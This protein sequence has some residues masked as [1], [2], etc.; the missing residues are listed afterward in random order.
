MERKSKMWTLLTLIIISVPVIEA[1]CKAGMTG[2]SCDKYDLAYQKRAYQKES[3][4][5]LSAGRAVDGDITKCT[6]APKVVDQPSWTVDLGRDMAVEGLI[7]YADDN[8][9]AQLRTFT[10]EIRKEGATAWQMCNHFNQSMPVRLETTCRTGAVNGQYVKVTALHQAFKLELC[11]VSVYGYCLGGSYGNYCQKTCGNCLAGETCSTNTGECPSGCE[12]G[13]HENTCDKRCDDGKWGRG[14]T[15]TCG[16]CA[17]AAP[18]S[19]FTGVCPNAGLCEP[20]YVTGNCSLTCPDGTTGVGCQPCGHCE[21]GAACNHT[22][23]TCYTGCETG[24]IYH[25]QDRTCTTVCPDGAWGKA[26]SDTCENECGKCHV[27]GQVVAGTCNSSTGLCSD[28]CAS[29]YQQTENCKVECPYFK[30]G[31]NCNKDC[32]KCG[33]GEGENR[34]LVP[35]NN[36]DGTCGVGCIYGWSGIFCD[37]ECDPGLYGIDCT[38]TCG[39]CRS[40]QCDIIDGV[41]PDFEC[42]DGYN[43]SDTTCKTECRPGFYGYRCANR[44]PSNCAEDCKVETVSGNTMC[45]TVCGPKDGSCTCKDGYQGPRCEEERIVEVYKPYYGNIIGGVIGGVIALGLIIAFVVWVVWRYRKDKSIHIKALASSIRQSFR[46]MSQR[47]GDGIRRSIQ[48]LSRRGRRQNDEKKLGTDIDPPAKTNG[49]KGH[50]NTARMY[51]CVKIHSNTLHEDNFPNLYLRLQEATAD[52][53]TLLHDAFMSFQAQRPKAHKEQ[54]GSAGHTN[55]AYYNAASSED[56]QIHLNG[57]GTAIPSFLPLGSNLS[58]FLLINE[59]VVSDVLWNHLQQRQIELIISLGKESTYSW[60]PGERLNIGPDVV[61]VIDMQLHPCHRETKLTVQRRGGQGRRAVRHLELYFWSADEL[62]PNVSTLLMFMETFQALHRAQRER[63]IIVNFLS[64]SEQAVFFTLA[65]SC[66]EILAESQRIDV[67]RTVA[68][69]GKATDKAVRTFE[70]FK[71]LHDVVFDYIAQKDNKSYKSPPSQQY[72]S[73]ALHA[74][75]PKISLDRSPEAQAPRSDAHARDRN[76]KQPGANLN[77]NQR[78]TEPSLSPNQYQQPRARAGSN[79]RQL[80]DNKAGQRRGPN[81]QRSGMTSQQSDQAQVHQRRTSPAQGQQPTS[82]Q[83]RL[84]APSDPRSPGVYSDERP[85]APSDPRSRDAYQNPKLRAP[86]EPRSPAG[87]SDQKPR[88]LTDPRSTGQQPRPPQTVDGEFSFRPINSEVKSQDQPPL[89]NSVADKYPAPK[90]QQKRLSPSN[91]QHHLSNGTQNNR[92]PVS[93]QGYQ[94]PEGRKHFPGGQQQQRSRD[95]SP[96]R[97][98]DQPHQ[99]PPVTQ[100]NSRSRGASPGRPLDQ[101]NQHQPYSQHN[102]RSRGASP[103]RTLDQP[104]QQPPVTQQNSRSRGASP[105]RTLD[106]GHREQAHSRGL[107]PGGRSPNEHQ[108]RSRAYSEHPQTNEQ[109]HE[110]RSR[111]PSSSTVV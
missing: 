45:T 103:G 21:G 9:T 15:K 85:R 43:T 20:G 109:D 40:G 68:I 105:G 33:A 89:Y 52:G 82:Q 101:P 23:G 80:Y 10:I 66:L 58:G 78:Q 56:V 92:S 93:P 50:H 46:R 18:C 88:A 71:F 59:P 54:N 108:Q 87:S 22:D 28:G 44:C 34:T 19:V 75:T 100:H 83:Q 41:C 17:D 73:V 47:G 6:V 106:P 5:T 79:E 84:R 1:Q 31:M 49:V 39:N 8:T 81:E 30:Y 72:H 11:E 55:T 14:C 94:D 107:S 64:M 97:T 53:R 37:K 77:Q 62:Y 12:A 51:E 48:R 29:G 102:S 26:S 91:Q 3:W 63:S 90:N 111:F 104:H 57:E 99:Q 24:Y 98:L 27:P 110:Q 7:I 96:G 67:L 42:A 61:E 76:F 65:A 86:S 38:E 13:Y 36:I 4:E 60:R 35:C 16:K 2:P 69:G 70:G 95:K 25:E 32:G 74:A